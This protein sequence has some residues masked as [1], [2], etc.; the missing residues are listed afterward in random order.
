MVVKTRKALYKYS[1]FTI[2]TRKIH[3]F[4]YYWLFGTCVCYLSCD[5]CFLVD[6]TCRLSTSS[7]KIDEHLYILVVCMPSKFKRRCIRQISFDS[8][9]IPVLVH[10]ICRKQIKDSISPFKRLEINK[11]VMFA[12][13]KIHIQLLKL[14]SRAHL[15][16]FAFNSVCL[17]S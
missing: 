13:N 7:I 5:L 3:K 11:C 4:Y 9:I 10:W 15:F 8:R 14:M 1:P 17:S 12:V 2:F 6:W 16:I